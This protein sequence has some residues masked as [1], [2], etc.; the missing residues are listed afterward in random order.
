MESYNPPLCKYESWPK[1]NWYQIAQSI[2]VIDKTYKQ[3]N[4]QKNLSSMLLHWKIGFSPAGIYMAKLTKETL[5]KRVK[6]VQ[7]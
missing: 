5:E 6:Y 4:N 3:L 2:G 1:Y 7:S